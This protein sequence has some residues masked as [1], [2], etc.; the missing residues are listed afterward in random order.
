[1]GLFGRLSGTQI[2]V[3]DFGE[4]HGAAA[5]FLTH[6]H[7][8]H[9]SGLTEAWC[10]KSRPHIWCSETT[11]ALMVNR[12]GEWAKS[13]LVGLRLEKLYHIPAPVVPMPDGSAYEPPAAV[14][15]SATYDCTKTTIDVRLFDSNHIAGSVMFHFESPQWG[16][17]LHTGDFRYD[18]HRFHSE[19]LHALVGRVDRLYF[20]STFCDDGMKFP[21]PQKSIDEVMKV[22]NAHLAAVRA[23]PPSARSGVP[24][25]I[26]LCCDS[27]GSEALVVAVATA[28][29][30]RIFIDS[31]HPANLENPA[32]REERRIGF[33]E[34]AGRLFEGNAADTKSSTL[35]HL[36]PITSS[37]DFAKLSNERRARLHGVKVSDLR[38]LYIQPSTLFFT[39]NH[40]SP[41]VVL[42]QVHPSEIARIQNLEDKLM[43]PAWKEII[44]RTDLLQASRDFCAMP[45]SV[46]VNGVVHTLNSMHSDVIEAADFIGFIAPL[47]VVPLE[48]PVKYLERARA[49]WA[50]SPPTVDDRPYRSPRADAPGLLAYIS[51]ALKSVLGARC[52]T[53]R[54]GAGDWPPGGQ[55]AA[56]VAASSWDPVYDPAILLGELNDDEYVSKETKEANRL[57]AEKASKTAKEEAERLRKDEEEEQ[58][59][60]AHE[61]KLVASWH[62]E[63]CDMQ[64]VIMRWERHCRRIG[65]QRDMPLVDSKGVT[66]LTPNETPK[67]KAASPSAESPRPRPSQPS[68]SQTIAASQEETPASPTSPTSPASPSPASLSLPA[69]LY[70][71]DSPHSPA[72]PNASQEEFI[73]WRRSASQE[74]CPASQEEYDP[75]SQV[76][77][78]CPAEQDPAP[79]EEY[80]ASQEECTA[81]QEKFSQEY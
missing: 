42:E 55:Y 19:K 41:I 76:E 3:D 62:D 61:I 49:T 67:R 43:W 78:E 48:S 12:L 40:F 60:V 9:T 69:S 24:M 10:R 6:A 59:R 70:I 50:N 23:E 1:M 39:L 53:V 36:V 4:K 32:R 27:L 33:G 5:F 15:A 57:A 47:A 58:Q 26:Y 81:S 80:I 17:I 28:L 64:R 75:C 22:I 68:S 63:G 71:S 56:P 46:T 79:Q 77:E 38:D 44:E 14:V 21:S 16:S 30:S 20:D 29:N 18:P 31:H 54:A 8:D 11:K 65:W 2:V 34:R 51:G 45:R 74:E 72:S 73:P 52:P 25:R 66:L 35:V 37:A 7:S 13:Y